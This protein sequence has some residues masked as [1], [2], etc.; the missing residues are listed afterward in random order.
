MKRMPF[1]FSRTQK[2][3]FEPKEHEMEEKKSVVIRKSDYHTIY[4][5]YKWY[6]C[7]NCSYKDIIQVERFCLH[8]RA[9]IK[10]IEDDDQV[11]V[12]I[13]RPVFVKLVVIHKKHF[14]IIDGEKRYIC[15]NCNFS[16]IMLLDE[17][18]SDCEFTIKWKE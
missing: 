7:P 15:P 12:I 8:C 13:T 1:K 18:C 4:D 3:T 11:E 5:G 10:W 9:T 2:L 6:S 14:A 16:L 17:K